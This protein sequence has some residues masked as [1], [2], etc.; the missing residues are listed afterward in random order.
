MELSHLKANHPEHFRRAAA[1]RVLAMDAV[2]EAN[3]G[4]PG[5]PMGMS[6]VATVL[7]EKHLKFDPK[8][9]NWPDRDR[10][11]LSAGHGSMLLYA[12]LY[13]TG[14]E[15]ITL[16]D[17]KRFRQLNSKTAGHPEFGHLSGI[18]TTTGPL[19]QGLGNA[20]GLA[21][22]ETSLA[23]KW[24]S[25]IFDH[26]TYVIAGDGCL[27]EGIS[28]EVITLAGK[29]KLKKLIVL[30]DNNRITIDGDISK[31]CITDQK[32]RFLSAGWS[33]FECDGHDPKNIDLAIIAAKNQNRPSLISCKTH[34]GFG[35]PNK[36][37]N[38]SAHGSPLGDEEIKAI[39]QIYGWNKDSF[40][41]PE[42]V[43]SDWKKIGARGNKVFSE[44]KFYY[45][46]MPKKKKTEIERSLSSYIPSKV[47]SSIKKLKQ[48]TLENKPNIATRKSSEVVLEQINQV[49]PNTMGGS[50]DLTGSNNTFT[51][52]M[53]VFNDENPT[54]RY[55]YYGIR[56]HGMAS[57]MNGLALHGGIIPYGG[58]FLVFSDYARGA[59]RLSALMGLRVI[60]VMTHDSIGLGE[61]GPTH[62]PVEH[63]AIMRATPNIN[64][65]RPADTVETAESWEC[66]LK[67]ANTPSVICLTR[68][69]VPT[70]L[71]KNTSKNLV[72]Y[73]A[74]IASEAKSKRKIILIATGSEVTIAI[75]AQELLENI[76]IGARV[77][78]MPC[79]ENFEIMPDSYKRKI[80]P[81]GSARIAI[82]AGVQQGWEK[83]LY[84]EGG[85]FKKAEFIGMKSFGA[86]GPGAD[87]FTYFN[88]TADKIVQKAREILKI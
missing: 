74:Y 71:R 33:V 63:L 23:A 52:S 39:K 54:G 50:A 78:S 38:A 75:N 42:D 20:V 28:Q 2:Q 56:E 82:E 76:G 15:D 22:A 24:G 37:D 16:E 11:I 8:N 31:T 13:L 53:G 26:Q 84:G 48:E 49:L 19:G 21:I 73:G 86:S 18:E 9:P 58:T 47:V 40:Y 36:Q 30:W 12:L 27:M 5:M 14:Y 59:I 32:T 44:W 3:S 66:A 69:S 83:W 25:N 35:S 7:F 60:Y 62:Q 17:I 81:P 43:K 65:F 72:E 79:W 87:L 55:V 10:F 45:D 85:S 68:Q 29:L 41:I 57:V 77:V 51:P 61:D 88:I 70:I 80:L 4:H 46:S 1:L 64:V 6:D 34:I 67:N